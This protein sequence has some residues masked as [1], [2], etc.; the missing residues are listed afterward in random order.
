VIVIGPGAVVTA[1]WG[2][3]A[4]LDIEPF[5]NTPYFAPLQRV[6][7]YMTKMGESGLPPERIGEAV[8]HALTANKPKV[9]YA[10]SPQPFADFMARNLPKRLLDR[11]IGG[12]LGL[13]PARR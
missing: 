8:L 7:A 5:R 13:L 12:R 3:A 2:K 10:V 6:L 1:I 9:R 4:E 11:M